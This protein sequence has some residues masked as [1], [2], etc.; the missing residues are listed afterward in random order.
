MSEMAERKRWLL[1]E[2]PTVRTYEKIAFYVP[3]ALKAVSNLIV[4]ED[5]DG[6]T[7]EN[8]YRI[9]SCARIQI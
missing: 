3:E 5:E 9:M 2:T 7:V 1:L 8:Y 6:E 4:A